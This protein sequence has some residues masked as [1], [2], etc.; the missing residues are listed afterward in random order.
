VLATKFFVPQVRSDLIARPRLYAR[1]EAGLEG[2]LTLVAA[3]P[4]CGKTTILA[5]WLH[6]Q[7]QGHKPPAV[8][9]L[10]LGSGD[11]DPV[12]FLGYLAA[13]IQQLC[14]SWNRPACASWTPRIYRPSSR[15][16]V[17]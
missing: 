5:D 16:S 2:A 6:A 8:A 11:N 1:L 13:A 12:R 17:T 10:S 15:Y 14:L 4:G 3:P 7:Q 9:W